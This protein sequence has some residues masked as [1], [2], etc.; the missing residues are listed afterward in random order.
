MKFIEWS[1]CVNLPIALS[2]SQMAQRRSPLDSATR[3]L[4]IILSAWRQQYLMYSSSEVGPKRTKK[5]E[6]IES[7]WKLEEHYII[8]YYFTYLLFLLMFCLKKLP[9]ERDR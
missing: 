4:S 6:N 1:I 3:Q 5:M 2:Q 7:E 9:T 8:K